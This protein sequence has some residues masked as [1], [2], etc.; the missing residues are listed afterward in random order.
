MHGR[1]SD[2]KKE[3]NEAC[4]AQPLMNKYKFKRVDEAI[5]QVQS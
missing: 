2:W 4:E 5:C 1:D 3:K